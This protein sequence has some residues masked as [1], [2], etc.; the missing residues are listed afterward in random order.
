MRR[1]E[2][3]YLL[4]KQKVKSAGKDMEKTESIDSTFEDMPAHLRIH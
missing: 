2:K 4:R 3:T 1:V